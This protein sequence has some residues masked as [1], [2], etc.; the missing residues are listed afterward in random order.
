MV[1]LYLE[2][3][4]LADAH[5]WIE[6]H[7]AHGDAEETVRGCLRLMRQFPDSEELSGHALAALIG[8]G[9]VQGDLPA[10][11]LADLHSAMED[12]FSRWPDSQLLRRVSAEDIKRLIAYMTDLVRVTPDQQR[13]RRELIVQLVLGKL[14][15]GMLASVAGRSYAEVVLRRGV[16]ALPA[17]H[18]D[19]AEHTH[20]IRTIREALDQAVAVDTTAAAVLDVLPAECRTAVVGTFRRLTTVDDALHDARSARDAP[21]ARS[22]STWIYDE[23]AQTGRLLDTSQEEADRLAEESQRLLQTIQGF[24]RQP[25][26]ASRLDPY[27]DNEAFTPWISL[28]DLAHAE[29]LPVWADDAALRALGRSVG[30]R[31]FS[32]PSVL[33]VLAERG[34][35]T[36]EQ[37]EEALRALIRAHVADVPLHNTRLLEIA[38]DEQWAAGAAAVAL[39]RPAAWINPHRAFD[40]LRSILQLVHI[41]RPQAVNDWL[42]QAVRGASY[43]IPDNPEAG[44]LLAAGILAAT[45]QLTGAQGES[46]KIMLLVSRRALTDAA[47]DPESVG[48]PLPTTAQLLRNA[49]SK[50]LPYATASQYV[51]A[52]FADLDH[53]DRQTVLHT[54]LR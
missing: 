38:E 10:D 48:D 6:L 41:H 9:S 31:A 43:A 47:V 49:L 26:P 52:V 21:A 4:S 15:L 29:G 3:S 40:L 14:P 22:T 8:P 39:G 19:P 51:L 37:H 25:R 2:P 7:R 27:L 36:P 45:I 30:L 35:I 24:H 44:N 50:A 5:A 1:S 34:S 20:S 46:A 42:Y 54:M 32:T 13:Q 23:H 12:F 17:W 18:P 28:L 16:G 53:H 33:H 11:L